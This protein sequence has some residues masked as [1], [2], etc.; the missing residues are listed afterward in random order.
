MC[1]A[2]HISKPITICN[3]ERVFKSGKPTFFG[4]QKRVHY[5]HDSFEIFCYKISHFLLHIFGWHLTCLPPECPSLSP[6][7]IEAYFFLSLLVIMSLRC[8]VLLTQIHHHLHPEDYLAQKGRSET[9][10]KRINLNSYWGKSLKTQQPYIQ[11][12]FINHLV[13]FTNEQ[14]RGWGSIAQW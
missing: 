12:T 11:L 9:C 7:L 4:R 14:S 1:R 2:T 10:L 8:S 5:L 6:S 3:R 13:G